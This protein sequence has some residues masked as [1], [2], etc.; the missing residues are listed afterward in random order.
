[1]RFNLESKTHRNVPIRVNKPLLNRKFKQINSKPRVCAEGNGTWITVLYIR[2]YKHASGWN[3]TLYFL[4]KYSRRLKCCI[5]VALTTVLEL[6]PVVKMSLFQ[7]SKRMWFQPHMLRLITEVTKLESFLK[8]HPRGFMKQEQN[9]N[10]TT[11]SSFRPIRSALLSD[12][13]TY[14]SHEMSLVLSYPDSSPSH[15]HQHSHP[16]SFPQ[17]GQQQQQV[18]STTKSFILKS[19]FT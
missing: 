16:H 6:N 9:R 11:V 7:N 5:K 14:C 3:H 13:H 15:S 18:F 19:L 4:I 10:I 2:I 8:P 1:M 17:M 12:M